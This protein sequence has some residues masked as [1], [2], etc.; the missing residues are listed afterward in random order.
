MRHTVDTERF[1]ITAEDGRPVS[2]FDEEG[3]SLLSRWWLLASW[4]RKY[5]YQFRWLGR[6]V[7]QLPADLIMIQDLIHRIRPTVI[8][9]TGIAHGG[10]VVFHASVLVAVHHGGAM[11]ADRPR[12]IAV[13]IEIRPHNREA[14]ESHPMSAHFT[15]V[16]GDS[17]NESVV[18]EVRMLLRDDDVV[19]VILDSGHSRAHVAGEL[20]AYGPLVSPGSAIV[21]MDGI[22]PALARLPDGQEEWLE[23]SPTAAIEEFLS[24]EAGQAFAIDESYRD[25]AVTHSPGGVLLRRET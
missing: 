12:V 6:P 15:L 19:L 23:D 20:R 25:Y 11:P 21:A 18:D 16:E 13:D 22:M 3:F 9:E 8:V 24:S 5:S 14:L 4:Q 10:S 1:T 17:T 7:I 2:W